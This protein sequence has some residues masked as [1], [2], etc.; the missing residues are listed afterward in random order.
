MT[1]IESSVRQ[2]NAPQQNVYNTLSNLANLEKLRSR[3]PADKVKDLVIDNDSIAFHVSPVGNIKFKIVDR[4]EPKTIK[5]ATEQSPVAMNF[6]VQL[7]PLDEAS[8]KMKLTVQADV[9]F[10]LKGVVQKPLE[11]GIEKIADVLQII[12]YE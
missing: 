8:C 5:F 6:W 1:K 10:F 12:H 4:E 3:I 9:P 7:L 11:Q 2:V